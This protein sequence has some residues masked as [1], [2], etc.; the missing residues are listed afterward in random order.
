MMEKTKNIPPPES[1]GLRTH[2]MR[3]L[4]VG[5]SGIL[6]ELDKDKG[7]PDF[8]TLS[9]WRSCAAQEHRINGRHYTIR[10]EGDSGRLRIWRLA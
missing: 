8:R 4:E 10:P 7:A 1:K 5:E 9:R 2:V 6:P 3:E